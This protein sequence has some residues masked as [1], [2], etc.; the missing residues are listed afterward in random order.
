M[1][2]STFIAVCFALVLLLPLAVS[3]ANAASPPRRIVVVVDGI[4]AIRNFP[5]V[6]A[7]RLGYLKNDKFAVTLMDIRHDVPIDSMVADGSVDAAIAYYHHTVA[8][9]ADGTPMA[10]I[11]TL[12]VTPGAKI[13][14]SNRLRDRYRTPADLKGARIVAGGPYSAKTTVANQLLITGGHMPGDYVRIRHESKTETAAMLREGKADLVV[15]RTPDGSFY[16]EAGVATLFLDL[17]TVDGTRSVLGGLFPTNA[18]YMRND[19]IEKDPEIARHLAQAFVRTLA[20]I[21]SHR[22]GDIAKL[23][24]DEIAG[25]DRNAYLKALSE[26]MAMYDNDG[27]MPVDGAEREFRTLLAAN[28]RYRSVPL[29][30]TYTNRFVDELIAK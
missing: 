9:H 18:I 13:M 23:I 21:R 12:G 29:D 19:R 14:V 30:S 16:E 28:P 17:T 25:K 3:N 7:E 4:S 27:K 2:R 22:A 5:V 24:P 15:A 11:V 6:L 8:A 1:M 20:Y 10:A 26:C